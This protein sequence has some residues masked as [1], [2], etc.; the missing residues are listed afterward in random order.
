MVWTIRVLKD[1]TR[2]AHHANELHT[3]LAVACIFL[4]SGIV[5][6]GID[7][8]DGVR[9]GPEVIHEFCGSDAEAGELRRARLKFLSP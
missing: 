5:V 4:R 7:S 1:N 9:V 2:F 8:P 3:A 6:E